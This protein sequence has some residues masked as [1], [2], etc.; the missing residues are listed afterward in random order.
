MD[1][2]N[3][4]ISLGGMLLAIESIIFMLINF[5]PSNTIFLMVIASFISSILIYEYGEKIGV[6]FTIASIILSFFIIS[7]KI[8]WFLYAI[9]FSIYGLIK[10]IIERGRSRIVEYGMKFV[11]ANIIFLIIVYVLKSFIQFDFKI[12]MFLFLNILFLVYDI[13]YSQFIR[14]YKNNIRNKIIKYIE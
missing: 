6:V 10:S 2:I 13:F 12:I 1:N 11:F 4:K 9:S 8:H 14:F 5:I 7:N 3:K